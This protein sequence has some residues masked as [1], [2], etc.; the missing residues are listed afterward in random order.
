MV[1]ELP[2]QIVAVPL[3]T[4]VGRG[5]TLKVTFCVN[6]AE[7]FGLALVVVIP[8]ICSVCP[9]LA[10]VRFAEVKL[11]AAPASATT[12]VTGVCAD[13]FIV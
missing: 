11:A 13:P 1:V 4:D 8:V 6:E 9:L 7:Q 3:T 12:P 10:A 5:F 2:L